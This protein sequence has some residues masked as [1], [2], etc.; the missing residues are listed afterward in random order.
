MKS[1]DKLFLRNQAMLPVVAAL[2]LLGA[3]EAGAVD[4]PSTI[5]ADHPS[6]YYRLEE[7]A[8]TSATDS[9]VNNVPATYIYNSGANDP[10]LG[11]PGITTNSILFN[12]GGFSTDVGFVDVPASP[13]ITPMAQDGI[14]GAPFSCE[15]WVQPTGV[16]ATY[17][18]PIELAA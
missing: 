5:L 9:S 11:L 18:V 14:H 8:G 7:T 1:T 12:G 10:Q 3:R 17:S 15:L 13:L 16:P 6:A 2:A 4:Y